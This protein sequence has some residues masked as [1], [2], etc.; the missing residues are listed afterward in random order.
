MQ[1]VIVGGGIAAV[2]AVKEIQEYDQE[3]HITVISEEKHCFYYRPL[4][5]LVIKGDKERDE[6]LHDHEGLDIHLVHG[7]A[8]SLNPQAREVILADGKKIPYEKLLIATG[9]SPLIPDIRGITEP[10]V[11]YLRTLADAQGLREAA[12]NAKKAVI[13][14]GGF[15]GIK[16]AEALAHHGIKVTVVEKEN[17][18]LLPRLDGDGETM[19]AERLASNGVTFILGDTINEI[20]PGAKGVKLASRN[21]LNCDMVCIAVGVRPN[22]GWLDGSGIKTDKAILIDETMQTSLEGVYA[23]GD[24]V[25][26]EDLVTGRDVVSALWTNAVEMGKFAGA[27]MAGGKL[28]YPGGLEILNATEIEGMPIVSVGNVLAEES[29]ATSVFRRKGPESYRKL[30]ITDDVLSGAIFIG[31]IEQAGLYT[32]IIKTGRKLGALKE[33]VISNT[34]S[35]ADYYLTH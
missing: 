15:V 28:K 34:L 21:E 6:L 29:G 10:N 13:L 14:G 9:S 17:Q 12:K 2:S 33:R 8:T 7:R 35:Y 32:S 23:A 22:I 1:Y 11:Y 30:V 4:T 3:S 26:I 25:Q 16:K 18:I 24:V 5:P 31:D 19:I 20:L 27:N